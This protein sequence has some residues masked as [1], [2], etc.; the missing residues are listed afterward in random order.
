MS[1]VLDTPRRAPNVRALLDHSARVT[2]VRA[3][4]P[5][6]LGFAI[7]DP[8]RKRELGEAKRQCKLLALTARAPGIR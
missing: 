1:E 6:R 4:A 3:R 8:L 5:L 2:K 7:N